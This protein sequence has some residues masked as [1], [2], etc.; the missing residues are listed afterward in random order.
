[1][2]LHSFTPSWKQL[3]SLI[4]AQIVF[5]CRHIFGFV[6]MTRWCAQIKSI[7]VF[8]A[9]CYSTE[10]VHFYSHKKKYTVSNS[11]CFELGF[12][13]IDRIQISLRGYDKVSSVRGEGKTTTLI[14]LLD[15]FK[16]CTLVQFLRNILLIILCPRQ[17]LHG[18]SFFQY[19]PLVQ[20][21]W[22]TNLIR[23]WGNHFI[24]IRERNNY[25]LYIIQLYKR[26]IQY[27]LL[28]S[29]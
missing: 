1:M 8:P 27:R 22:T 12:M 24:S 25:T 5:L 6:G 28:H 3:P 16:D 7:A 2:S 4:E 13:T 18:Y 17:L 20:S 21:Y 26:C 14:Q 23:K 11:V 19:I 15:H 29:E 9:T 10:H